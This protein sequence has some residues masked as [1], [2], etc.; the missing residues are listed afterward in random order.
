MITNRRAAAKVKLQNK[1]LIKSRWQRIGMKLGK[2]VIVTTSSARRK[3]KNYNSLLLM[4]IAW[5]SKNKYI[6]N[7]CG[8]D[9]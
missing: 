5:L 3:K 1:K 7:S 2:F 8:H 9:E 6:F 4:K